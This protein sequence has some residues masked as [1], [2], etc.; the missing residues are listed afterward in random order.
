VQRYP[1]PQ[2]DRELEAVRRRC[3][4]LEAQI[5]QQQQNRP[6]APPTEPTSIPERKYVCKIW[7]SLVTIYSFCSIA[8]ALGWGIPKHDAPGGATMAGWLIGLG[9]LIYAV[10]G[11]KHTSKCQCWG[12]VRRTVWEGTL[13][14]TSVREPNREIEMIRLGGLN[15]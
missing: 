12:R 7:G 11:K 2:F 14:V 15:N 4:D 3:D 10:F 9:A 5:C 1:V 13:R 6:T 8:L